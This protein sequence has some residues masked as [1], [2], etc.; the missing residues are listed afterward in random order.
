M[1]GF[2]APEVSGVTVIHPKMARREVK[3]LVCSASASVDSL[4]YAVVGLLAI[5][6]FGLGGK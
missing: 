6:N 3:F 4:L 5:P 2:P 1:S